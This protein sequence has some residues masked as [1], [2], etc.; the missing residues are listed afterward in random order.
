MKTL[1]HR[2]RLAELLEDGSM[3]L[4]YSG[5]PLHVSQDEYYPFRV[6]RNFFYLTGLSRENM[7]LCMKKQGGKIQ[8][9]LYIEEPD[10]F[11]IRWT[12]KMVT[13]DEA[14]EISGID[15]V[16]YTDRIDGDISAYMAYDSTD[17]VYFD[18]QR[19]AAEDLPDYNLVKADEFLKKYPFVKLY[20]LHTPLAKLRRVKDD[21]EVELIRGAIAITKAGLEKVMSTL[22]PGMYEYQVQ[23]QF[24]CEIFSCGAEGPSFPTIA[25][26]GANGTML[27]YETNRDICRDGDLILLDL[28]AKANGYCADITRTYPIN[29]KYS[30]RQ[31]RY[32]DIVLAANREVARQARP[33]LTTRD[34]NDICK[35]VLADGLIEMGKISD[36]AE[37]SG[38]Y[39]HGVSHHL[40]IDVHDADIAEGKE[41]RA[42]AV[43]SDEP[44]LYIDEEGIGIRI[45]DDLL[46]TE[47]GCE[48]L[49]SDIIRDP[50]EIEKFMAENKK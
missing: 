27:H 30:E 11:N 38:Y 48:V 39:M 32:Y 16:R 22:R 40:G 36:P 15:D 5:I 2:E 34:L 10:P 4:L 26:S 42:G 47:D 13:A 44:G 45:E 12:G 35:K 49:S 31:R 28:G 24:E 25:G 46:I 23:A 19:H 37:I 3:L 14:R 6:N 8:T 1:S 41:L 7:L 21:G 29:G 33:G 17:T 9:T 18:C 43:I 20:N 50:D